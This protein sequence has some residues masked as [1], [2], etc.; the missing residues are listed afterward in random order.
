MTVLS[1]RKM[2]RRWRSGVL[3]RAAACLPLALRA[4]YQRTWPRAQKGRPC[5]RSLIQA[6]CGGAGGSGSGLVEGSG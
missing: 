2:R 1:L 4:C 3:R 5:S 6:A